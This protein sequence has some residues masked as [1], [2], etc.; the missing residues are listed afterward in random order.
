V[1]EAALQK[2]SRLYGTRELAVDHRYDETTARTVYR[3]A[4]RNTGEVIFESPP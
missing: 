2:A 3:V 1:I 4:D